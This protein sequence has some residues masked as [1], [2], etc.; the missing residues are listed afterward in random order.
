MMKRV[1]ILLALVIMTLTGCGSND[2]QF[3]EVNQY[4]GVSMSLIEDT[5]KSTQATFL[6]T[7]NTDH[8]ISYRD[9]Y[10][11]EEKNSDG[12]WEEFVGTASAT[13]SDKTIAVAAGEAME[14]PINWKNLCGGI[15]K[16]EYRM[17]IEV[18][19]H[20]IATEFLYE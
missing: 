19:D 6:L 8:E 18:D 3:A 14:L 12:E 11:L 5:L 10:H 7:N 4:E 20:G 13:W 9:A 17:I 2:T 1:W 16:G 15:S